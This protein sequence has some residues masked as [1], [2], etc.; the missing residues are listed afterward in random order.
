MLDAYGSENDTGSSSSLDFDVPDPIR[1]RHPSDGKNVSSLTVSELRNW[2]LVFADHL[3]DNA[4]LLTS[5]DSAIG[6]A[7]HGVNM[8]RGAVA[9]SLA[10]AG[11]PAALPADLFQTAG[12]SL[13]DGVGGAAGPLYASFFFG[14]L[15]TQCS[16]PFNLQTRSKAVSRNSWREVGPRSAT[17]PWSMPPNQAHAPCRMPHVPGN[18]WRRS[19]MSVEG[20]LN[21][22]ATQPNHS[23]LAKVGLATW[24]RDQSAMSI[25]ARHQWLCFSVH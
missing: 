9:L 16:T 22:G 1:A 8:E 25:R 21:T 4:E 17:R 10:L 24:G 19:S 11:P 2:L 13:L 6:D 14:V 5:L 15:A 7:D 18:R 3:I 12:D 20:Q 23:K